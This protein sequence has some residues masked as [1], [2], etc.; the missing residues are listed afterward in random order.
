[1]NS[2]QY[3]GKLEGN[4][5]VLGQTACEKT[6]FIQNHAKYK[7][8]SQIKDVTWL[9][10]ITLSKKREGNIRSC[11]DVNVNFTYTQNKSEFDYLIE[12]FQ[13]NKKTDDYDDDDNVI[14]EGTKFERLIVMDDV[15]GL[16]DKSNN[17]ASFLTVARKFSF[18]VVYVF[19]TMYPSKQNWQMIIS[20]TKIF[21]IFPGSVQILSISKIL[22]ANCKRYTC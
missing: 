13:R 18:T 22:T 20:Q 1:M 16:A 5:L 17:F 11:F 6:A 10:N 12:N 19:H 4:I 8:F 7:L 14:D 21:N 3:D 2:Y 9:T 15:S